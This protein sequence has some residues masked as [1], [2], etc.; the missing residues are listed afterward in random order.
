MGPVRALILSAIDSLIWMLTQS[1]CPGRIL[2]SIPKTGSRCWRVDRAVPGWIDL[3]IR[4]VAESVLKADG[5]HVDGC[6]GSIFGVTGTLRS[7]VDASA[8]SGNTR[9]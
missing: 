9:S 1:T 4:T 5:A 6:I 8:E 2:L 3:R 7:T